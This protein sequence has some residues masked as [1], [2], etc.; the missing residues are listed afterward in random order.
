MSSEVKHVQI[1]AIVPLSQRELLK[2]RARQAELTISELIN[3]MISSMVID[4]SPGLPAQLKELNSWLGRIN[5][6]LNMLAHHANRHR[7]EA[8]S[9]LIRL[10]L[11]KISADVSELVSVA[12][13]LKKTN[14]TRRK[15]AEVPS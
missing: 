2:E 13:E 6:N 8:D 14:R 10:H 15:K 11:V 7:A 4:V 3:K 5:S 9:E 12:S 1:N